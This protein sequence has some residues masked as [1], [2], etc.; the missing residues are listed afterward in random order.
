MADELA[1]RGNR[2]DRRVKD[3]EAGRWKQIPMEEYA[4]FSATTIDSQELVNE[5]SAILDR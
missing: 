5:V 2:T 3:S 4:Y 1:R